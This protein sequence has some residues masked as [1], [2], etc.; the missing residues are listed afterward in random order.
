[1]SGPDKAYAQRKADGQPGWMTAE[2]YRRFQAAVERSF[3]DAR[4]PTS[5][6]LLELGC[7][8]GNM[9]VWLAGKGY[10]VYG[11][12]H[13]PEA[14]AWAVER[15]AQAGVAAR[16]AVGDVTNLREFADGFFAIVF[17]GRCFH[18]LAGTDRA[19]AFA[20][21]RRVLRVGG[22]FLMSSQC[23]EFKTDKWK[24]GGLTFDREHRVVLDRHGHVA[25]YMGMPASILAEVAAAGF[26]ILHHT[27]IT[28]DGGED[29]IHVA[30]LKEGGHG[31]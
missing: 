29:V 6:R 1:M 20:E 3:T 31:A 2:E 26:H 28:E 14:I 4:F 5:G 19:R 16:F 12:D 8:A 18:W 9:S 11:V 10:D 15:S 13:S 25:A 22:C 17:D 23:G 30:A 21:A 27:I 7:G 24:T